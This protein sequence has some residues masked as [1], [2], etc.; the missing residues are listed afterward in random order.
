MTACVPMLL[1]CNAALWSLVVGL[2]QVGHHMSMPG[3]LMS[4]LWLSLVSLWHVAAQVVQ[5]CKD[6]Q[7]C[8]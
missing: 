2:Q 7:T 1:C 4:L 5:Q 8:D 3:A 6:W